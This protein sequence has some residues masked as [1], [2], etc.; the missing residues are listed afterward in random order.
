MSKRM[1]GVAVLVMAL[2]SAV[3]MADTTWSGATDTDFEKG[4]NWVGATAPKDDTTTDVAVF[5][6]APPADQPELTLAE[7]DVKGLKVTSGGW[8]LFDASGTNVL[9]LGSYGINQTTYS[10]SDIGS[11]GNSVLKIT[12][13]TD[14]KFGGNLDI[15]S[16]IT[17]AGGLSVDGT[18]KNNNQ[19]VVYLY[20]DNDF[21]GG[22]TYTG[23]AAYVAVCHN[24]ALGSQADLVVRVIDH[25]GGQSS[26]ASRL[27]LLGPATDFASNVKEIIIEGEETHPAQFYQGK[28]TSITGT[29]ITLEGGWYRF[30]GG[31][32]KTNAAE[33]A[34]KPGTTSTIY[35]T[36]YPPG[37]HWYQTGVISGAG[38]LYTSGYN[39]NDCQAHFQ[40]DSAYTGGTTVSRKSNQS[41]VWVG[42]NNAFGTGPVVLDTDSDTKAAFQIESDLTMANDFSGRGVIATGS[43]VLTATGSMSPGASIGIMG[44]EDLM[45]GSAGDGCDYNFEYDETTSDLLACTTLEFGATTHA[46]NV[47]WLGADPDNPGTGE[48]VLFTYTGSDP[49]MTGVSWVV[50]APGSLAGEVLLD[51]DNDRVLLNLASAAIPEPGALG[52]MLLGLPALRRKRR[53]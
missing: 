43:Y 37:G 38:A 11:S 51:A 10:A 13:T 53:S 21:S 28:G 27:Y 14:L 45:F 3:A 30:T 20:G 4:G 16:K 41:M 50:N 2:A 42:H 5:S 39:G 23:S 22:V 34:L 26:Y 52:L 15:Y 47:N 1:F 24:N 35:R 40:G 46:V 29:K 36:D 18:V 12:T 17:G 25:T 48:Y 33:I 19:A 7:R 8:T 49:D 31:G 44:V 9:E 6:G 32:T